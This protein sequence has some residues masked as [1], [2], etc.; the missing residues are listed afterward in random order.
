MT[1]IN[2]F[3]EQ[4]DIITSIFHGFSNEIWTIKDE[5]QTVNKIKINI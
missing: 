4:N 3:K 2:K 1:I 5:L